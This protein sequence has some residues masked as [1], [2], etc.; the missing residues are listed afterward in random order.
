MKVLGKSVPKQNVFQSFLRGVNN[1][2]MSQ[3]SA[4]RQTFL[5]WLPV[6]SSNDQKKKR[7]VSKAYQEKNVFELCAWGDQCPVDF[8]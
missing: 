7:N 2:L 8:V 5:A 6:P 1:S 4:Y 3:K